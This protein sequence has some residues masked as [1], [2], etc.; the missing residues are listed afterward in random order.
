MNREYDNI[1]LLSTII[2]IVA[3]LTWIW[4]ST[5]VIIIGAFV[6]SLCL[7]FIIEIIW[8]NYKLTSS[9]TTNYSLSMSEYE[10]INPGFLPIQ[11]YNSLAEQNV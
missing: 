11:T 3:Y 7:L 10:K 2:L 1:L 9:N 6:I 4:Q 5:K 8:M